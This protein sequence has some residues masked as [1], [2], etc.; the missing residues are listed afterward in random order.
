ML[1]GTRAFDP[2]TSSGSPRASSRGEGNSVA[3]LIAAVLTSTPNWSALPADVPP[4]VVTLIQRCLE[5]DRQARIGDIAVARFLLSGDAALVAAAVAAP[6]EKT[7]TRWR[8]IA[9]WIAAAAVAGAAIGWLIPR[10]A[11][12]AGPLT[13]LQMDVMPADQITPS[14]NSLTRP[15]RTALSIS[16]DGRRVVF[17]GI[18]AGVT[19][20][21][22]RELDHATAA[23]IAGTEGAHAPF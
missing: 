23:P 11:I 13:H 10:R 16:P 19:Q 3:D 8:A 12:E 7:A 6:G 15:S 20:V 17:A 21:Y 5:K 9:P 2:S 4:Q 18:H 1:T 14:Q 22:L